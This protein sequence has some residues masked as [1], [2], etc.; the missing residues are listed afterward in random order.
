MNSCFCAAVNEVLYIEI[1][2]LNIVW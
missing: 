2:F 1:L